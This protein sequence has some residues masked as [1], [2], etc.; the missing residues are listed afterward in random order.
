MN[1]RFF[2]PLIGLSAGI[3]L[4][5][6]LLSGLTLGLICMGLSFL[7]WSLITILS[8][9]PITGLK[10]SSFHTLWIVSLFAGIG[11]IDYYFKCQP[12]LEADINGRKCSFTGKI[13]EVMTLSDGDRFKLKII[14]IE[15]E[16][17]RNIKAKNI[18]ILLK[19]NGYL[20]HKD[21]II[22]FKA[23]PKSFGSSPSWKDY[24]DRMKRQGFSY[25][26]N[27]KY[28]EIQNLGVSSVFHF[29]DDL[30]EYL[31]IKIEKSSLN[32]DTSEFLISILLGDRSFLSSGIK[33]TLNGAGLAH[34]L[35]LSGMHVAI[36]FSIFLILLFPLSLFGYN[37]SRK[38]I[39]L[40]LIWGY[41]LLTGGAPSTV[42]ASI[43]ASFIVIAFILERK[44]S[45]LNALLTAV[46]LILIIN[47][48]NLWDIGLQ[49]SFLCVA[50]I[51]IF[52]SK[53][54]PVDHHSHP[55]LYKSINV[56][57]TTLVASVC[58]WV[59]VAYYF[60]SVP[61][62]FLP[63]NIILLPLLP[64]F[65][66]TGFFYV[67]MLTLGIDFSWI[68]KILDFF[69]KIF[70]EG[71][72][73][74]SLSGNSIV[75][76]DLPVLSVIMWLLGILGIAYVLH[77]Q[78]QKYKTIVTIFSSLLILSSILIPSLSSPS[79]ENSLKFTYSFT[80]LEA[81]YQNSNNTT[82]LEFPRQ[83]VSQTTLD[84]IHILTV[85][86]PLHSNS[87]QN[88]KITFPDKSKY[89]FLG[90]YADIDQMAQIINEVDFKKII[91]HTSIGKNKKMEL[92][93]LLD[94]SHWDKVYSLRDTGSLD[95][96]L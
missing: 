8:K 44:N 38:I 83:N 71:A 53:L 65:V 12:Y 58:T 43:M 1:L 39:G 51:L 59:L 42:R 86:C 66:G 25:Y 69:Y 68:S 52:T 82:K 41:V 89:L 90:S 60:T 47:P 16:S 56:I 75:Q 85:D 62:L 73:V 91:L 88:L 24:A 13:E 9:N 95:L 84:Q 37:K 3:Y 57:L 50:S 6:Y 29:L 87:L 10:L 36:L 28:D 80:K 61:L 18:N 92:L 55:K 76:L 33:Q 4:S 79:Y 49:M 20:G 17:G 54:N 5:A 32:R 45:A 19:T 26:S 31:I 94:E 27:V 7:I 35:S 22:Y 2:Y 72:A 67:V 93:H 40:I 15:D 81:K 21:D 78:L 70:I 46:V 63:A 14:K 23:T 64:L 77:T 30:K 96:D 74:L 48:Y 34:V 11:S